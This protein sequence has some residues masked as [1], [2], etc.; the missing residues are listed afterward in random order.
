MEVLRS[1]MRVKETI[2]ADEVGKIEDVLPELNVSGVKAKVSEERISF[3]VIIDTSLEP[4][5]SEQVARSAL[6][7][8]IEHALKH[9]PYEV[10]TIVKKG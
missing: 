1:K 2:S 6:K 10:I 9:S 4:D 7:I 3:E 8:L 5:H